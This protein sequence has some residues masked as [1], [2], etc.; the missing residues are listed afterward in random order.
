MCS[1]AT[2][3][4]GIFLEHNTNHLNEMFPPNHHE[5]KMYGSELRA[6]VLSGI[7]IQIILTEDFGPAIYMSWDP[8]RSGVCMRWHVYSQ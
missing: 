3:A 5:K 1:C 8:M 2:K 7:L 4:G 6:C